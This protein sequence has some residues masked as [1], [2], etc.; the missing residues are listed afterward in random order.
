MDT[1]KKTPSL[2][3]TLSLGLS[4]SLGRSCQLCKH[5]H[6]QRCKEKLNALSIA[7]MNYWGQRVRVRVTEAWDEDGTHRHRS[8]HYEGR[9][10]DLTTSDRDRAKYGMLARLARAAGFDW[11]YYRSKAHVHVSCKAG[12]YF[13][14]IRVHCN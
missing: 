2:E 1:S 9:A 7:V 13:F 3:G 14:A 10:L 8:L 6:T 11:V 5:T 12:K 4:L